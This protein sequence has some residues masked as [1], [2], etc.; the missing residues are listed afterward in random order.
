MGPVKRRVPDWLYFPVVL[1]LIPVLVL[2]SLL[3]GIGIIRRKK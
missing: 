3:A 2:K 1:L